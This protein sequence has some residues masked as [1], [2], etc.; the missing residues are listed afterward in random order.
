VQSAASATSQ[1]LSGQEGL[2]SFALAHRRS[3]GAAPPPPAALPPTVQLT[4]EPAATNVA[5][6][7]PIQFLI[8]A[9]DTSPRVHGALGTRST[10]GA[11]PSI[12]AFAPVLAAAMSGDGL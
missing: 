10:R 12:E 1:S 5:S 7:N 11:R 8:R 4:A 6:E 3:A 2:E 9:T